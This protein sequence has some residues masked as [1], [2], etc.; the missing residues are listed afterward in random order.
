MISFW[1]WL[2]KKSYCFSKNIHFFHPTIDA[3]FVCY[4]TDAKVKSISKQSCDDMQTFTFNFPLSVIVL[5]ALEKINHLKTAKQPTSD[6]FV[7]TIANF[8][9]AIAQYRCK[10]HPLLMKMSFQ[11]ANWYKLTVS[12]SNWIQIESICWLPFELT[13]IARL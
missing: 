1:T 11:W 6:P 9:H 4:A 5:V 8:S 10:I 2:N 12:P 7:S 13:A 3:S